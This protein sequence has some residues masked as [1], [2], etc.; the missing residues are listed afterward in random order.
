[1]KIKYTVIS[2][3]L[4]ILLVIMFSLFNCENYDEVKTISSNNEYKVK[5]S[6][7]QKIGESYFM[8]SKY[9]IDLEKDR[10][11]NNSRTNQY[12]NFGKIFTE[13]NEINN[14]ESLNEHDGTE[15]VYIMNYKSKL[16]EGK[17]GFLIIS[18]DRRASPILAWSDEQ[19]FIIKN[20]PKQI[21]MWLGYAQE[22]VRRAKRLKVQDD[23]IKVQWDYL[24]RFMVD[25]GRLSDCNHPNPLMCDPCPPGWSKIIGPLTDP[26]SRWAQSTGYN[27]YMWSRSCGDCNKAAPGCAAV[28]L[29]MIMRYDKKPSSGI[30]NFD[31]MPRTI[32]AVCSGLT[33][34]QD[35]VPSLLR[36]LSA[37]MSSANAPG[38]CQT[39][40]LP[41]NIQNGFNW[42]GYSNSGYSSTDAQW[43]IY[44][45]MMGPNPRP[46][47]MSGTTGSLNLSDA[48]YWVC[49]GMN[50]Y[51]YYVQQS[52]TG[53]PATD[54]RN[55]LF[56]YYF[57]N[58][59]WGGR[60]NAWYLIS[61]L[62]PG[63][64]DV[65][66]RWLRSRLGVQP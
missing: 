16:T 21:E 46:V 9:R 62:N 54:C 10:I 53:D 52:S 14:I 22:T 4:T 11:T 15:L 18:A 26:L 55:Y 66:D 61:N 2:K 20:A 36:S 17:G 3:N 49:D 57:M 7:L 44:N 65:Y 38:G 32:P 37:W 19:E 24:D 50:A 27:S 33:A 35:Q 6:D 1:M 34:S 5:R 58:W 47:L 8:L 60:D 51:S 28:A 42:G 13:E 29:G 25:N 45:I 48:H 39:Y 30:F 63:G 12:T 40:T 31:T 43:G 64:G 41:N 59:G 23:S 56:T